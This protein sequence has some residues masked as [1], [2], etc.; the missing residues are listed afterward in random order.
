MSTSLMGSCTEDLHGCRS[1]RCDTGPTSSQ[2]TRSALDRAA[3][4]DGAAELEDTVWLFMSHNSD[5][6]RWTS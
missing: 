4:P 1:G 2:L 6:H 5:E 3:A